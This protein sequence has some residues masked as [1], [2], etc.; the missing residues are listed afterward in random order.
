M[1]MFSLFK[2]PYLEISGFEEFG[3][4]LVQLAT[5]FSLPCLTRNR[6]P[7]GDNL[8]L[9]NAV[10]ITE[11]DTNLRGSSTLPGQLANLVDNLVGVGLQP[12]GESA[13]IGESRGRNAL[14]LAVK[15][16][17]FVDLSVVVM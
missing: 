14:T 8:D 6:R 3:Y 7:T 2:G 13:R 1:S 17:H 4:L 11:N 10:G 15:S 16:T 9:G 5:L 12:G